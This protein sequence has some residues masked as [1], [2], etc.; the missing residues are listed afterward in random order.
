MR[1][2]R[3]IKTY[4]CPTVDVYDSS[5]SE[6]K[7]D[8]LHLPEDLKKYETEVESLI[9]A[10]DLVPMVLSHDTIL[11]IAKDIRSAHSAIADSSSIELY[12]PQVELNLRWLDSI[13]D[14]HEQLTI[15]F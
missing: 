3:S 14:H 15:D 2:H 12:K 8:W 4:Q 11:A 5:E 1:I 9:N 10:F 6:K 7:V 13:N